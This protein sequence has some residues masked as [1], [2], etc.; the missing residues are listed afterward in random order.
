VSGG[1]SHTF[2]A[3]N[4]FWY[5]PAISTSHPSTE[6]SRRS[7]CCWKVRSWTWQHKGIK[8]I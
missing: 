8:W 3:V 1:K 7:L 4:I 6:I 5:I 2:V